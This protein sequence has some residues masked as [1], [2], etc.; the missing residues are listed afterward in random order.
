ME[1]VV[2][3]AAP[4]I[5]RLL[6]IP[7]IVGRGISIIFKKIFITEAK[8]VL[9]KI[10]LDFPNIKRR[11]RDIEIKDAINAP[12]QS[13]LN[14]F[15]EAKYPEPNKRFIITPGKNIKRINIGRLIINIHLDTCLLNCLIDS[16]LFLEY[17][18]IITG[19]NIC[20]NKSGTMP[21]N[22]ASGTA[23]LYKPTLP[24]PLKKPKKIESIQYNTT[25][26]APKS[27]IGKE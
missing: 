18:F 26:T 6:S 24:A 10:V 17:S 23:A 14:A 21:S 19:K 25:D 22:S 7:K 12:I 13:S 20:K 15:I 9:N 8:I 11:F 1:R 27:S 3:E 2:A 5:P 16:I 4:I